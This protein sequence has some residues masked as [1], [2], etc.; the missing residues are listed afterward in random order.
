NHLDGRWTGSCRAFQVQLLHR[1]PLSGSRDQAT[2][3]APPSRNRLQ[4]RG[5][6]AH[7]DNSRNEAAYLPEQYLAFAQ[8]GHGDHHHSLLMKVKSLATATESDRCFVVVH[9]AD[10]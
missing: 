2:Q 1:M 6:Y 4:A 10:G 3:R 7:H 8:L 5:S 9:L